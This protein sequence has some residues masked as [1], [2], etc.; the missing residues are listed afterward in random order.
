MKTFLIIQCII[1]ISLVLIDLLYPRVNEVSINV[2]KNWYNR[3]TKIKYRKTG[4]F[5]LFFV[6]QKI[7]N[8]LKKFLPSLQVVSV[9]I[10]VLIELNL[11]FPIFSFLFSNIIFIFVT[12]YICIS[13]RI[14]SLNP[15]SLLTIFSHLVSLRGTLILIILLNTLF[16]IFSLY[17]TL[18]II[19]KA[20]Q[21]YNLIKFLELLML[22]IL[23]ACLIGVFSFYFFNVLYSAPSELIA[24][25]IFLH[26]ILLI[27]VITLFFILK[28]GIKYALDPPRGSY[29]QKEI[30]RI[31]RDEVMTFLLWERVLEIQLGYFFIFVDF[32][33]F[34]FVLITLCINKFYLPIIS[35]IKSDFI[36]IF[37]IAISLTALVPTIFTLLIL[38]ISFIIRCLSFFLYKFIERLLIRL[39]QTKKGFISILI[40]ILIILQYLT[41]ILL[42]K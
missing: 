23:L 41:T 14:I 17:I 28:N 10:G 16:D 21:N 13:W 31:D 24:I 20:L 1:Y 42:N 39:I 37:V 19:N 30:D 12:F 29:W 26:Y 27:F 40:F 35:G 9:K 33:L 4:F 22:D 38:S 6:Y 25:K 32:I 11:S 8:I 34:I 36:L 5:I 2:F 15:E 7:Q 3:F 18:E